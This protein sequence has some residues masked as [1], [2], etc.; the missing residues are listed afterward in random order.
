MQWGKES[1]I[2]RN[3]PNTFAVRKYIPRRMKSLNLLTTKFVHL[4]Q[5]ADN[6]ELDLRDAVRILNVAQKRRLYD[7]TN[8]LQG[9]GLIVKKSK[10]IVKWVGSLP[11]QNAQQSDKLVKLKSEVQELK[12]MEQVL[13]QQRVWVEQSIANTREYCSGL[14][15]VNNEDICNSFSGHTVLAVHAPGGTQLDVPIP[16]AV[17]NSSPVYQVH[18]KSVRGPIDVVFMNKACSGSVPVILPV[19]PPE[20]ILQRAKLALLAL[21]EKDSSSGPCHT[22]ADATQSCKSEWT[23]T[24]D[25][26]LQHQSPL[27][28]AEPNRTAQSALQDISK[29]LQG[30]LDKP[31]D[32]LTRFFASDVLSP[33]LR[34]SSSPSEQYTRNLDESEAVSDLFDVPALSV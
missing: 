22:S 25:R 11:I 14:T 16:K 29:E 32:L 28:S 3:M 10:R 21:E 17:Q 23:A 27:R 7:I 13:D 6:G 12:L 8:V 24:K 18:L 34:L 20:E 30:Q 31:K 4:L 2:S 1:S 9:I 19:P 5:N 33:L 26:Q 15:Y